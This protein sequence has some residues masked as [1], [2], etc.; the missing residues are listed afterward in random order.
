[1]ARV[2]LLC[3]GDAA[4][5][6]AFSGSAMGLLQSLRSS[7]HEVTTIDVEPTGRA[8]LGLAARTFAFHRPRWK[9]RYRLGKAAHASRSSIASRSLRALATPA[10][11]VL[12]IGATFE[13]DHSVRVPYFV[14]CDWNLGLSIKN[15]ENPHSSVHFA[16]R[17][18]ANQAQARQ[19]KLYRRVDRIFAISDRLRDSFLNDF[20]IREDRVVTVFG[21]PNYLGP[22]ITPESI[23]PPRAADKDWEHPTILFVGT[24]FERKGGFVLLRAF[25][26]IRQEIPNA[27]LVILGR[28]APAEARTLAGVECHEFLQKDVPSDLTRFVTL[29]RQANVF[30]LPGLLDPFPGAVRE[31]MLYSLPC[32]VSDFWALPEM[33]SDGETGYTAPAGD[34]SV[35]A[36]RLL[37]LLKN[38]SLASSMG[39][40]GRRRA[41]NR[42]TWDSVVSRMNH[43]IDMI[44]DQRRRC[45]ARATSGVA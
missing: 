24:G 6:K 16:S 1:M 44:R 32:V 13:L 15:R 45:D 39:E 10:E 31:A 41:L 30:C 36:S 34:A 20:G 7:G 3:E 23:A 43:E 40:A 14:Y 18:F 22:G 33:V 11:I 2:A 25:D 17:E 5:A 26:Q 28:D 19:S 29:H 42:F 4:G 8:R 27:R 38:P 12:Q 21:G 9:M 35:L 37:T